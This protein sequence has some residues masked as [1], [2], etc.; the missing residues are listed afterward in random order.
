MGEVETCTDAY[1]TIAG[2]DHPRPRLDI[3]DAVNGRCAVCGVTVGAIHHSGCDLEPCPACGGKQMS[4]RCP[5]E[6]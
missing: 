2:V 6:R 1:V 3:V 5:V 4:C